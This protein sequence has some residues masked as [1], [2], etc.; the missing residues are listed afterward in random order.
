M[1]FALITVA[2]PARNTRPTAFHPAARRSIQRW[3]AGGAFT[4]PR[5]LGRRFGAYSPSS[6]PLVGSIVD[7]VYAWNRGLSTRS[8]GGVAQQWGPVRRP[9][10]PWLLGLR[11]LRE[12]RRTLE[13]WAKEYASSALRGFAFPGWRVANRTRANAPDPDP[14]RRQPDAPRTQL[15]IRQQLDRWQQPLDVGTAAVGSARREAAGACCFLPSESGP[16]LGA[17]VQ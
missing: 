9:R 11:H 8:L 1:P 6:Q 2:T 10:H 15:R 12:S 14:V 7:R 5:S 4:F 13:R 16:S 3:R 17:A